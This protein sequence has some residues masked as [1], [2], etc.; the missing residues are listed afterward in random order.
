M[1]EQ[2]QHLP[3]ATR[4]VSALVAAENSPDDATLDPSAEAA[5]V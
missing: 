4:R 5:I 1:P 3:P 2:A